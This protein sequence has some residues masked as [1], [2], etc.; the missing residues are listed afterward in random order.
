MLSNN[1]PRAG[2]EPAT[3]G[4]TVRRSTAWTIVEWW[5]FLDLNQRPTGYEPVALT[6]WAKGPIILWLGYTPSPLT[7]QC[8]MS[9][10]YGVLPKDRVPQRITGVFCLSS[11]RRKITNTILP[12]NLGFPI[13]ELAI[14]VIQ[15][16]RTQVWANRPVER[17]FLHQLSSERT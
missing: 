16:P 6:D 2:L 1:A 7:M 14:R 13:P 10:L 17:R 4:L 8:F 9:S 3:H 5:A 15:S 11:T 12:P